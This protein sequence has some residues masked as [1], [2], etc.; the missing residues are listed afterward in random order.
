MTMSLIVGYGRETLKD[1]SFRLQLFFIF[2]CDACV[3]V[4]GI[5]IVTSLIQWLIILKWILAC[6]KK[7][8]LSLGW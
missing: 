3:I 8:Q 2:M 6:N 4:Y 7:K 5:Y 1:F